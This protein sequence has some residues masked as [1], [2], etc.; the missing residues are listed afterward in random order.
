M[1]QSCL[2]CFRRHEILER[3][4]HGRFIDLVFF[5]RFV[6]ASA[7]TFNFLRGLDVIISISR[8]VNALGVVADHTD[9]NVNVIFRVLCTYSRRLPS[10]ILFR[11]V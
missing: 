3:R 6:R 11:K 9:I 10:G 8:E 2:V 7:L 4:C 5:L 1:L